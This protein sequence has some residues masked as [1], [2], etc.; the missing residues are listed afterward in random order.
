ML[1]MDEQEFRERMSLAADRFRLPA[2]VLQ[3]MVPVDDVLVMAI[4]SGSNHWAD[5]AV[6]WM[7]ERPVREGDIDLLRE[8]AEAKWASQRTRHGARHLVKLQDRQ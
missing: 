2:A 3:D 6:M 7:R 4:K 8:L 1:D 5:R